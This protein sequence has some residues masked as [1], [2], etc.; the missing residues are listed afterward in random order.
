[1][2]DSSSLIGRTISHFRIIEK[3]G[4]GGMGVVY[5]AEDVTLHRFAALKFLPDEVAKDPQALARF[6]REAQAAS[7][8]NH[9]NIC[10]I[11]EIGE[12]NG[13]AYI[14]MEY[15]DGVM[16]KHRISGRPMEVESVLDLAIEIADA[17]DAAHAEGIVHRDIKPANIFITKRGHAKILDFGLAKQTRPASAAS[18]ATLSADAAPGMS[19]VHLT[20][21]GAVVG[22]M[23]YMSPEQLRV[24]DLDARTDLFSFGVVLYEMATGTLPFRG[25]SSAVITDAILNHTPLAAIRLNPDIPPKLEDVI[26]RAL[27]KD[28]NLRYQ[29]AAEMRSELMRVK[30]DTESARSASV[31]SG[32]VA[33]A[34]DSGLQVSPQP[35][36][37][38]GSAPAV[39][40][41]SSG[42]QVAEAPVANRR[43]WKVLV[44]TAVVL[45]A[46][47]VAGGLY[48]HSRPA[49]TLTEKDTIVLADFANTTGEAVFDGTLK[50]ALAVDLEQSPVLNILS[51]KKVAET[52]RLMGR[53]FDERLTRDVMREV[54][55]RTDSKALV[56]GSI[57]N[58][59]GR[60][61]V[62]L[63]A[64]NCQTGDSLGAAEEEAD[65]QARVLQ[66][67]DRAATTLRRKLGESLVS[68]QK[69]DQPLEQ[70]TT[71]SLEALKAYSEGK[72]TLEKSDAEAVPFFKRAVELD[73][74]FAIAYAYLGISYSNLGEKS[75]DIEASTRAYD[76]RERASEREKFFI[77]TN[78]YSD[79]TG[80]LDK[81]DQQCQLW[82]DE[83]PRDQNYPHLWLGSNDFTLG[84]FELAAKELRQHL[85]V[86]PDSAI[87]YADLANTYLALD[88]LDE[89]K[90]A[91]DSALAH[92]LDNPFLHSNLYLQAFL[93][94]DAAGMQQEVTWA[95]G[96]PEAEAAMLSAQSDTEAYYGRLQS[97]REYSRHAVDAAKRNNNNELA[98]LAEL[99]LADDDADF[100]NTVQARQA[101]AVALAMAPAGR[102]V[103]VQAALVLANSKDAV[104]TQKL[105]DRLSSENPLG[106]LIQGCYLPTIRAEIEL[107]H[108][109]AA[110]AIEYLERARPYEL[111]VGLHPAYVRA[112][113]YLRSGQGIAAA[114]EFQ[115]FLD[116][117]GLMT[118][119]QLVPLARL[120]LARARAAK[121]DTS[122][123]RTAYQDFLALWKAADPDIP[124]LKQAKAEYAKLQ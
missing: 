117:R 61:A 51:D 111:G 115:K 67:M 105:V 69:F 124:I 14:V 98:A 113:A 40:S 63:K 96:K 89:A 44:P 16:L 119:S 10:T 104:Q 94:G 118:N 2:A 49:A 77:A 81:A 99:D 65:G 6:Q 55:Q 57:A 5:K 35:L 8:L 53:S 116:H 91:I 88:R 52:L 66:A 25:E 121:G 37:S 95:M 21:P 85:S 107:S 41:L 4:G 1:M 62:G 112:L 31:S 7:A 23:A 73:P 100:G 27:E 45:A 109:N 17:L 92:K 93:R 9:P 106:T 84:Q 87:A 54:C 76:L 90:A 33:V 83:Y 110:K 86:D 12:E 101:A 15:L 13:R 68:I 103:Q 97:A 71:S 122:G 123:A 74:N 43:L 32:T 30:R 29:G 72:R 56:V 75:L 82:I 11:Y 46:A 3:L 20:S 80:E 36:P 24:K 42:V 26:N 79:V 47:L 108:G 78:Y 22:T 58:L 38:S 60:Y 102:D 18:D 120:G 59:G 39:T 114:T 70:V 19:E 64:E 48:F 50:E 34:Q 28:R